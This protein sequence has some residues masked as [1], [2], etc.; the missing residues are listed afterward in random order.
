MK[1]MLYSGAMALG[2]KGGQRTTADIAREMVLRGHD[3]KCVY[4]SRET[5]DKPFY[6]L[7]EG[8]EH[9]QL[10]VND[11]I[12]PGRRVLLEARKKIAAW[13]P[14]VFF[15]FVYGGLIYPAITW[16]L[17]DGLDIPIGYQEC[18]APDRLVNF[19]AEDCR[20]ERDRA[21]VLRIAL[22]A[23]GIR[24]RLV[25]PSYRSSFP[26]IMQPDLY[27]FR[28]PAPDSSANQHADITAENLITHVGLAPVK[29]PEVSA[30]AFKSIASKYPDWKLQFCGEGAG[31]A[32]VEKIVEDSALGQ[33]ILVRGQ[34]DDMEREY[35]R[36]KI[37]VAPSTSEGCPLMVLEAMSHR[38][39]V[40]GFK[41]CTGIN[42]LI[43]DGKTGI[44]VD[45]GVQG[46]AE[47]IEEF[48]CNEPR[49]LSLGSSAAQSVRTPDHKSIMDKW[50]KMFRDIGSYRSN[51]SVLDLERMLRNNEKYRE[52][53]Q[54][55]SVI[56]EIAHNLML[57]NI[58]K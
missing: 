16:W 5:S 25:M 10:K 11:S 7:G 26:D 15:C 27:A 42:E 56:K 57:S 51:P 53:N 20:V 39:P 3:V 12:Y 17:L 55:I 50:E 37:L 48:I 24:T 47:A 41:N 29:Q 22:Y 30:E 49:R 33:Q 8:V 32:R 45:S 28:N 13:Q 19:L 36:S 1:I 35:C 2:I 38:V 23:T 6:D 31:R 54:S 40:I 9:L 21:E 46:I 44:L 34:V 52:I 58:G 4:H 43:Q 14:D 18:S